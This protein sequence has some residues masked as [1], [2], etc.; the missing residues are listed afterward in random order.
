MRKG[1]C[2]AASHG[3][4]VLMRSCGAELCLPGDICALARPGMAAWHS[5]TGLPHSCAPSSQPGPWRHSENALGLSRLF[6][7]LCHSPFRPIGSFLWHQ[8]SQAKTPAKGSTAGLSQR[9]A[10]P[11]SSPVRSSLLLQAPL[12]RPV[13]RGSL[14]SQPSLLFR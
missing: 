13:G 10:R 5:V 6:S 9:P 3:G 1:S 14:G 4:R 11:Q 7:K 2:I 12:E 8:S